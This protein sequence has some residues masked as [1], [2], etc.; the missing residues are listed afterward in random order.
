VKANAECSVRRIGPTTDVAVIES[1]EN[2]DE[3]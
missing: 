1:A 2:L 3:K